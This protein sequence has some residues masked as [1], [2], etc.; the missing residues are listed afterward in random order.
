MILKILKIRIA[1]N[2]LTTIFHDRKLFQLRTA[3]SHDLILCVAFS[4]IFHTFKLSNLSN[5]KLYKT[6]GFFKNN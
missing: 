3:K 1:F 6:Y 5:D 2:F 4:A